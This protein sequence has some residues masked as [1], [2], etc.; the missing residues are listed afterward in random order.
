MIDLESPVQRRFSRSWGD[1]QS[2]TPAPRSYTDCLEGR[3]VA[4]EL[5][6]LRSFSPGG[7]KIC[8]A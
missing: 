6:Y 1:H 8:V 3:H 4:P 2:I 5:Q 7:N